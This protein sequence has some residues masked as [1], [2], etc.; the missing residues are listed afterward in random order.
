[1]EGSFKQHALAAYL[2]YVSSIS[3][4]PF[5]DMFLRPHMPFICFLPVFQVI[6]AT[7]LG[8]VAGS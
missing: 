1:M 6:F 3:L 4:E 2:G 5:F 8:Q 7:C